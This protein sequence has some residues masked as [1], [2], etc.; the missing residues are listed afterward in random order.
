MKS[1]SRRD[2]LKGSLAATGLTIVASITPFGTKLPQ[3]QRGG[4]AVLGPTA[5]FEIT[6]DN[7]VTVVIPSSEMGQ[8]S[9]PLW[10]CWWP[11][12]LKPT[13]VRSG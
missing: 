12:S 7:I 13:G 3:C 6:P 2:F 11:M 1:I 8:G 5:F 4:K 10:Q 9:G